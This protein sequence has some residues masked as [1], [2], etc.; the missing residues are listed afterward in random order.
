MSN[1]VEEEEEE[2]EEK[3]ED[4]EWQFHPLRKFLVDKLE[5]GSIPLHCHEMG[6]KAVWEKHSSHESFEGMTYDTLFTSGLLSL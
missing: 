3:E 4:L 2:N 6:P 5:D 1:L